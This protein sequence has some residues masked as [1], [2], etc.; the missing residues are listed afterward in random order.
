SSLLILIALIPWI[1]SLLFFFF[2]LSILIALPIAFSI[3][4]Y[5]SATDRSNLL[6]P[7]E[8][9]I[10]FIKMLVVSTLTLPLSIILV[11]SSFVTSM[12]FTLLYAIAIFYKIYA[13][14]SKV[15]ALTEHFSCILD[16]FGLGDWKQMLK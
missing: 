4:I 2:P 7:E 11:P 16:L 14:C 5:S 9:C 10:M 13:P 15:S 8:Y 6:L 3:R 1:L 12:F